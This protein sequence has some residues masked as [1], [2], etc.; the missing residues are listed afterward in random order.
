M[1]K[2][3]LVTAL[4]AATLLAGNALAG[5]VETASNPAGFYVNGNLGYGASLG[6][7]SGWNTKSHLVWSGNAGYQFNKYIA[8]EG[9]YMQLP[10]AKV[11]DTSLV[12]VKSTQSLIDIVAKGIYPI[13]EQ[14]DVFAK[15]GLGYSFQRLSASVVGLGYASEKAKH[16]IVPVFGA[17][18]DYNINSNLAVTVQGFANMAHGKKENFA[19]ANYLPSSLSGLVGLTYKF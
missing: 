15:A 4:S 14:F 17:G 19:D 5:S 3:V 11:K 18:A 12:N 1:N 6:L 8:V 16:F 10:S 7:P 2:L 9:G 13:N